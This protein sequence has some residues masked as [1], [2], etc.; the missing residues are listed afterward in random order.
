MVIVDFGLSYCFS[1]CYF[2]NDSRPS[3]VGD[4]AKLFTTP[5][6]AECLALLK[7]AREID[8]VAIEACVRMNRLDLVTTLHASHY[9]YLSAFEAAN[10]RK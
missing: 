5:I 2:S 1:T 10:F 9:T 7:G 3:L 4:I 8:T 6:R